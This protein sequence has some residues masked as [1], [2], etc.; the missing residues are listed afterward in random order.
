MDNSKTQTQKDWL[1][2]TMA[3]WI[4]CTTTEPYT[5]NQNHC[6]HKFGQVCIHACMIMEQTC[7]PEQLWVYVIEYVCFMQNRTARKVLNG[8]TPLEVMT[9][10]TPDISELFDFEFYQ[11]VS[12]MDNPQV[13]FP[14]QLLAGYCR[15]SGTSDVLLH[16]NQ[17]GYGHC[18]QHGW[19]P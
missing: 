3:H 9:G 18:M 14:Q 13:K 7:C 5:P 2:F 15:E 6:Y 4:T 11:S 16:P 12:Y 8:R 1:K 17:T 10:S 19:T